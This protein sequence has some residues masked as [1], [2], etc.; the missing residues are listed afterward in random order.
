MPSSCCELTD[1]AFGPKDARG[2]VREYQQHGPAAQTREM[3]K[4]VRSLGLRDLT[5]LD[6]GGGV[7]VIHHE[8]LR[9]IAVSAIHVDASSAYLSAAREEAARLG[10]ADRVEFI[11]AD[12]ADAA[13]GLPRVD[14]VTLDRVVCCYPDFAGLLRA[15]ADR[16][17]HALVLSYPREAWYVRLAIQAP[18][19][20]QRLRREAF[21]VFVHPVAQMDAVLQ[22]SG[23]RRASM[24]KFFVWEVALFTR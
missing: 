13:P 23:L 1:R 16:C 11:H 19:L 15:A 24:K 20:I 5:L 14:V 6:I 22:T 4:A 3:L 12:F 10:H 17:L 21:R 2:D 7:G 9:D 18:N 8:L